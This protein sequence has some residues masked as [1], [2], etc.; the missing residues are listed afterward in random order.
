[1]N[2]FRRLFHRPSAKMIAAA[3]R[4]R[5]KALEPLQR[6]IQRKDTRKQSETFPAAREATIAALRAEMRR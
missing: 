2:F 3:E 4:E 5:A 6:A 1:M